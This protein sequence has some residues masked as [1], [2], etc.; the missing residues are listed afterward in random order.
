MAH[1]WWTE[2]KEAETRWE[3][4]KKEKEGFSCSLPYERAYILIV[5]ISRK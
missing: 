4:T 2:R 3:E 1:D 5:V